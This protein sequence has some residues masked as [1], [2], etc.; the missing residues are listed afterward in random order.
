MAL[1]VLVT[2]GAG[3][4]GSHIVRTLRDSGNDVISCGRTPGPGVEAVWDVAKEDMPEPDC[5]PAVVVH[6]AAMTGRYQQPVS[7]AGPLFDVN[8]GG[9]L[10]VANWCVSRGVG[11]L[12]LI[13]GAIVYGRWSTGPK[14]E[15][16]PVMPWEAGPYAVSK[17]CGEQAASLVRK[18]HTELS[19]LR[20]SSLYGPEYPNG[21]IQRLLLRGKETGQ[22]EIGAPLDDAFD[23]L[24]LADAAKTVRSS[25]ESERTGIWNVGGGELTT[26]LRLGELCA[27]QAN[28]KVLLSDSAANRPARILNWVDDRNARDELGHSNDM[29]LDAATAEIEGSLGVSSTTSI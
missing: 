16:D 2:G 22:V 4:L 20:L 8:V 7:E 17:F 6:A 3:A 29:R 25:V 15:N 21:I 24:H 23:L 28:A 10:R 12:V 26:I 11:R 27:S 14:S 5:Q 13:S 1:K 9:T 19:I 18:E